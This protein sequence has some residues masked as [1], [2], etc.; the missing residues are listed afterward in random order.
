[1]D[2]KTILLIEGHLRDRTI[3]PWPMPDECANME[4]VTRGWDEH[5]TIFR[6]VRAIKRERS[7]AAHAV[8]HLTRA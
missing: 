3:F 2:E 6:L 4:N 8:S 5:E 7:K 1:M